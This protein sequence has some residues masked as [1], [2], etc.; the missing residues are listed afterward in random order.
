MWRMIL[1][2]ELDVQTPKART[3]INRTPL[4]CEDFVID[5]CWF[6]SWLLACCISNLIGVQRPRCQALETTSQ[7]LVFVESSQKCVR[8]AVFHS[9]VAHFYKRFPCEAF[10]GVTGLSGPPVLFSFL[11]YAMIHLTGKSRWILLI[12]HTRIFFKT[13]IGFWKSSSAR[14]AITW[15]L[16][17]DIDRG[18]VVRWRRTGWREAFI[19]EG[20]DYSS[21]LKHLCR[22]R[23]PPSTPPP[24]SPTSTHPRISS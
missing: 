10:T 15:L 7:G 22:H 20:G 11:L 3:K 1:T 12:S 2:P 4:I 5:N 13:H 19:S 18:V 16:W 17:P 8:R 14:A 6:A 24:P 23:P 9:N 21:V